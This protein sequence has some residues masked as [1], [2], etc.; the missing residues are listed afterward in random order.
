MASL[1]VRLKIKKE[2]MD[3][4]Q[5]AQFTNFL[6]EKA[7]EA[8]RAIRYRPTYFLGMLEAE[9][10]YRTARKLLSA[11]KVSE[12]FTK[13]FMHR[14]LD[15]SV[16][17]L[18]V[19]SKWRQYFD[20]TL[21]ALAEKRLQE[22]GYQFLRW[23]DGESERAAQTTSA[24][25]TKP[26]QPKSSKNRI[27]ISWP[28]GDEYIDIDLDTLSENTEIYFTKQTYD[29]QGNADI[30]EVSSTVSALDDGRYEIRIEYDSAK[31]PHI[32]DSWWG[33]TRIVMRKNDPKGEASWLDQHHTDRNGTFG[34]ATVF[35]PE[36]AESLRWTDEDS[37][38]AQGSDL[39]GTVRQV[40]RNERRGQH[41]FRERVLQRERTC[42]LTG[43]NDPAHLRA[44]H[45][46]PWAAS[47]RRERLD[48]NNGLMLAPHIDHR[49]DRA[50]I[51]FEDDGTLLVLNDDIAKLLRDWGIVRDE[52]PSTPPPFNP[53]QCA[54]L[55][56][57]RA[58]FALRQQQG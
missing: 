49:V 46:K 18:V 41:L 32:D 14:R 16:E 26:Q 36:A 56:H 42:R 8:E 9:G 54:Y 22:S 3:K 50:Y 13:L 17:A 29:D 58:R 25:A 19:E 53:Q 52:N 21:L 7:N 10:G 35:S 12:G 37:T 38:W 27:V 6:R 39:E 28:G 40:L 2:L 47:D 30:Y 1:Q 4:N 48:A 44:S 11:N 57:H 5:E 15:L 20:A 51:S 24:D 33:T 55:A 34:F 31:N 45:I 23:N 43:V